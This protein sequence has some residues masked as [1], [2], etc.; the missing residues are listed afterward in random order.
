AAKYKADGIPAVVFGGKEYGTGSSRDWAAKGPK[1]L[2][3]RAV[4][5]E[6]FERIHRS[7]LVGMGV[8]PFNFE[9]GKSRKDYNLTGDEIIDI[10]GLSGKLKPKMSV[11]AT[12]HRKDGTTT[13]LPLIL[14]LL[15]ADEVAYFS[16]G[17]ILPYVLRQLVG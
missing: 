10:P 11:T 15:T 5:T 13:A 17:G 6:S 16:N 12:I 4:I 2:G 14:M 1:L 7:N 3:V 8:A 9:P